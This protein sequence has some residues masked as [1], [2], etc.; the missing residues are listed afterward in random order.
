MPSPTV[1][2]LSLV[3]L[4]QYQGSDEGASIAAAKHGIFTR[5]L[6]A[7]HE[8][9]SGIPRLLVQVYVYGQEVCK[10]EIDADILGDATL[11]SM[12]SHCL[13]GALARRPTLVGDGPSPSAAS[14]Q[15]HRRLGAG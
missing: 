1:P 15:S 13:A 5:E 10:V 7:A 6:Y 9:A 4:Q 12:W 2:H 3:S 11:A 8:T 14:D